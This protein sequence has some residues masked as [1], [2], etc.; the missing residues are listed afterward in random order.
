MSA[1]FPNGTVFSMAKLTAAAVAISA[2]S[3]ANPA[4]ASCAN[5]PVD[6]SIGVLTSGW[7]GINNR[8]VRTK[9]EVANTSFQLENFDTTDVTQYAAGQGAGSIQVVNTADWVPFSQV[10]TLA[11]SG[12]TQQYFQ[13]QYVEDPTGL[14]QQRPTIKNAKVITLTFD[15]DPSLAWYQALVDADRAKSPVVLR[16]VLPGGAGTLYYYVYPSFDG[17]PT[18]EV[19]KNM[20]NTA[21]FSLISLFTR[22]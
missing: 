4:V 21:T 18:M 16:A 20:Q 5:P 7:P 9:G 22:Y 12:G 2:I 11:K 13:W 8:V 6:G 15:Y 3:N 1:L 19:N 10:S 14:Q 17:D